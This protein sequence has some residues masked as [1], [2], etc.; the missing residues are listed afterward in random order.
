MK[1]SAK[2]NCQIKASV[3]AMSFISKNTNKVT[4]ERNCFFLCWENCFEDRCLGFPHQGSHLHPM[5][6]ALT[7]DKMNKLMS[8]STFQNGYV[9]ITFDIKLPKWV[10]D[11]NLKICSLR[12]ACS[13]ER[14]KKEKIFSFSF[15]T[16]TTNV[17]DKGTFITVCT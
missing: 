11:K 13:T 17:N 1:P 2:H 3:S 12:C 4:E 9:I 14:R 16:T 10:N 5:G 6:T 7:A 15:P 8:H